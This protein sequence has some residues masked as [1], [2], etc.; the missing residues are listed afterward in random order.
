[1]SVKFSRPCVL[2]GVRLMQLRCY[3]DLCPLYT[4]SR[5]LSS[6]AP[7]WGPC[8]LFPVL[9]PAKW[10]FSQV[11]AEYG[12]Y[13]V[14]QMGLIL[15][16]SQER[17]EGKITGNHPH[18]A[19]FFKFYFLSLPAVVYF[20]ESSHCCF[21][22]FVQRFGYNHREKISCIGLTLSWLITFCFHLVF[23]YIEM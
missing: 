5:I 7:E 8:P 20:S 3:Q 1:M 4:A 2:L 16:P 13:K 17:K 18:M 23:K 14:P 22:Y 10:S 11:F 12:L 15:C 6:P 21:L 19:C 9:S